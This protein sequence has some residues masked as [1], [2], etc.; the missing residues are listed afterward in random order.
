MASISEPEERCEACGEPRDGDHLHL[1]NDCAA[2]IDR[3][4]EE[5]KENRDLSPEE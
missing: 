1:C 3:W 2:N 4:T 5:A